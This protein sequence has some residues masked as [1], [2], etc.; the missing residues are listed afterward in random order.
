MPIYYDVNLLP[1]RE[2][3]RNVEFA[4]LSPMTGRV[5][6]SKEKILHTDPAMPQGDIANF[7]NPS[8]GEFRAAAID[9]LDEFE[10]DSPMMLEN[11][12]FA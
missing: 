7:L 4:S 1:I 9:K 6:Q 11:I 3:H 2:V 8:E 10:G 12:D 5:R